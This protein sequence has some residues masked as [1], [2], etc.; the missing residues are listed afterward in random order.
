MLL[1]LL[2]LHPL[3]P[4]AAGR[5]YAVTVGTKGAQ[6]VKKLGTGGNPTELEKKY[7]VAEAM[8]K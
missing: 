7:G 3:L 8:K 6:K 4:F 2:P 5:L 1:R